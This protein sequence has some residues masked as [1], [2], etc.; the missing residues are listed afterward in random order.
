MR[1]KFEDTRSSN[2]L[3]GSQTML[4]WRLTVI[5][6]SLLTTL[7]LNIKNGLFSVIWTT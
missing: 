7:P 4:F 5:K 2:P 6:L 3:L 1:W